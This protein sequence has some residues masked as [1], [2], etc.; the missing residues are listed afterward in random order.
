MEAYR[1]AGTWAGVVRA[2]AQLACKH[3][4]G[5]HLNPCKV[6]PASLERGCCEVHVKSGECEPGDA[7]LRE[8]YRGPFS[9]QLACHLE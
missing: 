7:L 9:K 4:G 1:A 2:T 6:D 3:P 5:C 8:R